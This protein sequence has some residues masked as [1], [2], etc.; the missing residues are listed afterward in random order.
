MIGIKAI[1]RTNAK[2]TRIL[3]F[4]AL[5]DQKGAKVTTPPTLARTTRKTRKGCNGISKFSISRSFYKRR[6]IAQDICRISYEHA[7]EPRESNEK[8][9]KNG[10][11]ARSE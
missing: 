9:D 6:E 4:A 11:D 1:D 8:N 3:A 2:I 10:D 7:Q 5:C